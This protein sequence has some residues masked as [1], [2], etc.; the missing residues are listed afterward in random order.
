[1]ERLPRRG[2]DARR[3]AQML[4]GRVVIAERLADARRIVSCDVA[5]RTERH[6]LI[7]GGACVLELTALELA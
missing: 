2:T 7:G 6:Q 5:E 3:L 1:M 4:D